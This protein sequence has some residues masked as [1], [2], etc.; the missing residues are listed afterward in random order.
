MKSHHNTEEIR[1]QVLKA[2]LDDF[3]DL[4][5]KAKNYIRKTED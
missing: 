5:E 4:R 3:P 2:M 1:W